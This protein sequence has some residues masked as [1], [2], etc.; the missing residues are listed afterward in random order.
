MGD[1]L[2][3]PVQA[4]D[5]LELGKPGWGVRSPTRS[6][7]R[8][9]PVE[10]YAAIRPRPRCERQGRRRP[11]GIGSK[12][13]KMRYRAD[14]TRPA[15]GQEPV[16][17]AMRGRGAK[18]ARVDALGHLSTI[19]NCSSNPPLDA[20]IERSWYTPWTPNSNPRASNSPM[21]PWSR[22]YQRAT[23]LKDERSPLPSSRSARSTARRRPSALST[24]WVRMAAARYDF[25][26]NQSNE[27]SSF[28]LARRRHAH[29]SGEGARDFAPA[30]ML[31]SRA[32]L[33]SESAFAGRRVELDAVRSA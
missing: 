19:G 26:Q 25:G 17:D 12:Q 32:C 8:G 22:G 2:H 29:R 9:W 4:F 30:A 23:M 18:P 27:S 3:E 15:I 7:A 24:S 11:P 31:G 6:P 20:N 1:D 16:H 5:R 33:G 10:M 21:I 28:P 13:I 14:H